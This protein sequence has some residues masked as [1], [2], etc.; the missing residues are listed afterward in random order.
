MMS[1]RLGLAY[2]GSHTKQRYG[3]PIGPLICIWQYLCRAT[4]ATIVNSHL[5]LLAHR[6]PRSRLARLQSLS[7]PALS[8]FRP[9]CQTSLA[10]KSL[11]P[12]PPVSKSKPPSPTVPS[13]ISPPTSPPLSINNAP[14]SVLG[15]FR[16]KI[17]LLI[18]TCLHP[19]R[20]QILTQSPNY[21]IVS[22]LA[23]P[24]ASFTT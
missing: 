12:L 8:L 17:S 3:Y 22:H 2:I 16:S 23:R 20:A 6:P 19:N 21:G 9:P 13:S 7:P 1:N 5:F 10:A 18:L 24:Y 15:C 14:S 11:S 4:C